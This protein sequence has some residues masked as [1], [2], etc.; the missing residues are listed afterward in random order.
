MRSRLAAV[1]ATALLTL[2]TA[3][4]SP[5]S[6]GGDAAQQSSGGGKT[7]VTVRIWDDQVAKAYEQSFAAFTK[8]NPDI[9]VKLNLVPYADYFTKLPLDVSSGTVDDIFWTNTTPF[10]ALADPEH[11]A[12]NGRWAHSFFV[13]FAN[14]VAGGS[15]EI[16]RN[17]IATRILGLPR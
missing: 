7:T 2:G 6:S 16:Q 14:T 12:E 9:T 11:G 4:C 15:S 8:A 10:G 3:A 17:I 13:S 5:S 1:A